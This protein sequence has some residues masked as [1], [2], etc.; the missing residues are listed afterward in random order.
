MS[1]IKII[2]LQS[3]EDVITKV[4]SEDSDSVTLHKPFGL[5]PVPGQQRVG[6][7]PYAPFTDDNDITIP[8]Q[9]IV[10]RTNAKKEIADHYSKITTGLVSTSGPKLIT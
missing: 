4:K 8:K 9:W 10:T 5:Y 3:G 1:N 2:R 6:L 7:T